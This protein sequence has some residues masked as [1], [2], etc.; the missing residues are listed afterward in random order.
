M[1]LDGGEGVHHQVAKQLHPDDRVDEEQHS[2][3][4]ADI[5]KGLRNRF[6]YED[7]STL[8]DCMKV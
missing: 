1:P 8:N 2:H 3:Q 7:E 6:F 4:H 5:G